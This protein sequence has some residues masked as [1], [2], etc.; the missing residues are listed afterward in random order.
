VIASNND[1]VWNQA[2]A[3]FDFSVAPAYYQTSWFR[4]LCVLFFFALLWAAHR[5][6]VRQLHHDF[7]VTLEA[8]VGERTRIARELHDTLLQSFHGL[9][10]QLQTAYMLLPEGKGKETLES[11]IGQASQAITEGRDAVQGLRESTV[12]ANDLAMA[13]NTLGDELASDPRG[14]PAFR[15]AVEGQSRNLHPITRDEVYKIAAEAL[16]NAFRHAQAKQ[17][18]VEIRYDNGV[19]RLRVRD[20]GKGV[21]PTILSSD[22]R[23]RH[24]GLPGMRERA[25]LIG[26]K[27][28]IWSEVGAGTEVELRVPANVA[29]ESVRRSSWLSRLAA[30]GKV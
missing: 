18:E 16:R 28:T 4:A 2:G 13:I 21:E 27:L 6:H 5:W 20:D 19:F 24:Y 12:Q 7:E 15:V 9:L 3:V 22:G 25:R 26:A 14:R 1:G 8:R 17:V 30:G 23:E 11:A 10:L 29:Y